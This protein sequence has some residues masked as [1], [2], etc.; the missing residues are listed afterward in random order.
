MPQSRIKIDPHHP[1][2]KYC[3]D[4]AAGKITV[5]R[6]VALACRRHLKDL[7][8]G[9]SRGLYFDPKSAQH[10]LDFFSFLKHSKGEYAGQSFKLEP[11]QQFIIYCV[12]GWKRAG[13]L[14]RFR[15]AY[16]FVA[17]KNGKSTFAAGIGLYLFF[18][19][20]E[21]GAEVYVAATKKDQAR[22]VFKEAERMRKAS[23]A[24][25]KRIQNFRDNMSIPNTASKF[26]P[27]GADEDTLDGLNVHGAIIDEY[28]AH[29]TDKVYEV[30]DTAT[31]SRRQPLKF[32]IT[33]A[34]DNLEGPCF[35]QHGY[36]ENVLEGI[37]EDDS[38]FCFLAGLDPDDQ[39]TWF[40]EKCWIKANP[41]LL[42]SVKIDDLRD[43]AQT[44]KNMNSKLNGFLT[45][46]L[47]VWVA[48]GGTKLIK[49]EDWATC[50][51]YSLEGID[52]K[53][54]RD[55]TLE[56]LR[57]RRCVAGMDLSSKVDLTAYVKLFFPTPEDPLWIV[58]P[59]F[60][61]PS[62]NV[63]ERVKKDHVQYDIWI[64][65][66]FITATEGNVVDYDV[67]KRK[68][69][70]DKDLF[71]LEEVAFDPWNA[72]QIANQLTEAGVTMVE[73]RQGYASM[74]DPT[75]NLEVLVKKK[76][77]AHLADPVL[78]WNIN[79]LITKEDEAGNIKPN[80]RKKIEKIDGAVALI[81]ALGRAQ[82]APS[83]AG[84]SIYDE[85]G[86][87]TT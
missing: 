43:K 47:N 13:G 50:V 19:D 73:F 20:G 53:I 77:I 32:T 61:V 33:T 18:A 79:N 55:R 56:R 30:I 75:K 5:S 49:P 6:N 3:R 80:K 70:A 12:F 15:N 16:V 57:G 37:F 86:I 85:M 10:A 46:H 48:G 62:E 39:K 64:R 40:E 8:T 76:K 9:H 42:V 67:I 29:K 26:E 41:N 63:A 69:I 35:K 84:H 31:G 7:E 23:P 14:R 71:E 2:E 36:C 65:E 45:K 38:L 34:G 11:W 58:V 28:H 44:A 82:F 27:L 17:R 66:G 22:I 25:A 87:R 21:P 78:R 74:S 54:L 4:A 68:I 1:A 72:T 51:G 59:E 24:L 52:P 83:Q 81:M 60:F